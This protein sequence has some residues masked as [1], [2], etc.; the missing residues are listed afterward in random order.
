MNQL[1]L[2]NE[3]IQQ[4]ELLKQSAKN[5]ANNCSDLSVTDPTS[6]AVST[7]ALSRLGDFIRNI[8]KLRKEIKE[9]YLK[10]CQ[11][12]DSLAKELSAPLLNV[13]DIKKAAILKYNELKEVEAKKEQD[14]IQ[15]I[16]TDIHKYLSDT[17]TFADLCLSEI[18]LKKVYEKYVINFPGEERWFEFTSESEQ[19]KGYLIDYIK[20]RKIQ[21][22]HPKEADET[23]NDIINETISEQMEGFASEEIKNTEFLTTSNIK[24]K[25]MFELVD[26]SQLRHEWISVNEKAVKE[27]IKNPPLPIDDGAIIYGIRFYIEKQLKIK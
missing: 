27:F 5:I 3:E 17:V 1:E 18:D 25:M 21:I 14:R 20:Q 22:L 11:Q 8:E 15:S 6:L 16:K 2:R 23:I 13:L 26:V 10:A 19:M 7:Q 4:F 9:P 24:D 12:I